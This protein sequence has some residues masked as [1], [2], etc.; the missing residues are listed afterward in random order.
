M[1]EIIQYRNAI[2]E[3]T[4]TTGTAT[5]VLEGAD[6]GF[7]PY[8]SAGSGV[9]VT[10][11]CVDADGA[12]REMGVGT[13]QG[14]QITRELIRASTNN[15]NKVFFGAGL[16]DI[17]MDLHVEDLVLINRPNVL[18]NHIHMNGNRL[19]FDL[20]QNVWFE[21]NAALFLDLQMDSIR[22]LRLVQ[23]TA[24]TMAGMELRS[25]AERVEAGPNLDIFRDRAAPAAGQSIGQLRFT[26][27]NS[28]AQV[29]AYAR[30]AAA[31]DNPTDGSESGKLLLSVIKNGQ[32]IIPV[33][34]TPLWVSVVNDAGFV[35]GK[36]AGDGGAT[37][38]VEITKI[39]QL[40]ATVA[41][42][43][44][45]IGNR[46]TND[47]AIA[48]WRQG[49]T[50]RGRIRFN[51]TTLLYEAFCG[52]HPTR[53]DDDF[54]PSSEPELGTLLE[55]TDSL[56]FPSSEPDPFDGW[57]M[58]AQLPCCRISSGTEGSRMVYGGYAGPDENGR[59][60]VYGL[61]T[62]CVRVTGAVTAGDILIASS[63]PG[64]ARAVN[65]GTES[66]P[67]PNQIVGKV[68]RTDPATYPRIVPIIA[69]SA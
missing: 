59:P 25:T 60:S 18:Q 69:M 64:L 29:Q 3:T 5:F 15:G 2:K 48:S 53:W 57:V 42:A 52:A 39:G 34:I 14:G 56:A 6:S 45:I 28:A 21:S 40:F 47:G 54:I 61:G 26:S 41:G 30:I 50:E 27:K 51:G 32:Q 31:I 24:G 11:T 68:T 55:F 17:W 38:G 13:L 37:S 36:P 1:S 12:Q 4:L 9:K 8:A 7:F 10:Y 62:A 19:S 49:G 16:K 67:W 35:V 44:A 33:Q 23:A 65:Q 63:T 20:A 58:N 46:I 66:M 22:L 43:P